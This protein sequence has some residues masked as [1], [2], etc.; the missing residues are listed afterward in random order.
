MYDNFVS[1]SAELPQAR[2]GDTSGVL[3]PVK[4]LH[5]VSS[6]LLCWLHV[7]MILISIT[8]SLQNISLR[9]VHFLLLTMPRRRMK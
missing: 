1:R 2:P 8:Q 9:R 3:I 6:A 4:P 7:S 5:N